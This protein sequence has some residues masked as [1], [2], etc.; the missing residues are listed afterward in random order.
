MTETRQ[1]AAPRGG[2]RYRSALPF[3]AIGIA[4]ILAG[5]LIAA[6]VAHAPGRDMVWLAAYLVLVVG[7]AQVAFG[8]GQAALAAKQTPLVIVIV[9]LLLFNVG[10][11]GVI[12]GTLASTFTSVAVGTVLLL[13]GL[14][15]FYWRSRGDD[16]ERLRYGYQALLALVAIGALVGV[17]LSALS[18]FG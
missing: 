10:N 11:A 9:E 7:L 16:R 2:D 5:G 8:V 17:S 3:L 6:A 1:D 15:L 14:G 13:L 4:A 18:S 12:A